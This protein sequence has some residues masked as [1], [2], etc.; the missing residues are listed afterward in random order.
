MYFIICPKGTSIVKKSAGKNCLAVKWNAQK[1]QTSGYQIQY[2][3]DKTFKKSSKALNIGKNTATYYKVS[4]LRRGS[5]YY[6]RI[7]TYKNVKI[8]GK[9]VKVYS[10]WSKSVAVRAK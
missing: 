5:V 8:S 7:R 3:T 10:A 4:K 9:V 1:I 6:V 2:S